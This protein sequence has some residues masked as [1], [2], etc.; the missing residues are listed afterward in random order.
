MEGAMS[1]KTTKA[2]Q[3]GRSGDSTARR[4]GR[5]GESVAKAMERIGKTL[6]GVVGELDKSMGRG[7]IMRMGAM[8]DMEM[9]TIPSGSIQLD[10]ALGIG[11]YPRGRVIEVYGPESSGK[12]TLCL[13]AI[14]EAQR[15]GKIAAFVDAEHALDIDYARKLGVNVDTLLVAQPDCGE[16]ALQVTEELLKTGKIDMV[17][18]DS[19]AALV[20]RAELEGEMGDNLVGGHA[21]LMNRAMRKL[22]G[23]THKNGANIF[24]INQ[25][26]QKIGVMFGSS[27]TTT[28]GNALKFF[29][30]VRLDIRRIQQLKNADGPYGSR[31]RVKVVKNK[32]SAPYRLAE[33]D[34]IFGLGVDRAAEVLDL[35]EAAGI[36]KKAG[37]WFSMG[38]ERLG[39][40]RDATLQRI[41]AEDALRARLE[42]Q[43]FSDGEAAA[44]VEAPGGTSAS[45]AAGEE[46]AA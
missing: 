17:V 35:A 3:A 30:S 24:F 18:V 4:K 36:V 31:T 19:V 14:A 11:G 6:D 27:E 41:R 33:F 43:L 20:P 34:I 8:P 39:Q 37:S 1:D 40:G 25:I 32:V 13:H 2:R 15:A 26:R 10:R 22:T 44:E 21:R 28:G 46:I 12:T 7:T 45:A 38:D 9:E 29:S 5:V 16:D 23:L 42:A